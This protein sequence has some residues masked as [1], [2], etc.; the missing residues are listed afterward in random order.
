MHSSSMA[1]QTL[2]ILETVLESADA[3]DPGQSE[4]QQQQQHGSSPGE[5][6]AQVCWRPGAEH[7]C[8][9]HVAQGTLPLKGR[10]GCVPLHMWSPASWDHWG[11]CMHKSFRVMS[12]SPACHAV[13]LTASSQSHLPTCLRTLQPL[14]VHL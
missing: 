6:S 7:F 10:C 9:R 14:L 2:K 8:V 3:E 11:T 5:W 12:G 4:D 1:Q 13:Q